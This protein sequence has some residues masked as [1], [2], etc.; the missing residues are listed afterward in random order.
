MN[1]IAIDFETYYDADCTVKGL[2]PDAYCRHP[3]FVPYMVSLHGD[4]IDYVGPTQD[5]PWCSIPADVHFVAHNAAFDSTVFEA[6]QRRGYIPGD[7]SPI[8]DCTANLGV[9]IQ[10]PR[11]LKG[12]SE[13]MLGVKP[14]KTVRD[15]MKGKLPSD[16]DEAELKTLLEYARLDAVYCHELWNTYER[17]WPYHERILARH[18]MTS[19]QRGIHIDKPKLD[20]GVEVLY[21][22]KEAAGKKVPWG[23][24]EEPINSLKQLKIYCA[25]EGIPAPASTNQNEPECAEWEADYGDKYP[26]VAALRDW[27]KSNR[28]LRIF[29]TINTRLR[30]DGT[31]PFGLKYFGATLTGR[32]SGDTGLNMQNLPRGESFG[33]DTR[34]LFVP[35]PG[36]KFIICDLAQIEPRVMAWLTGNSEMLDYIR[37]GED[38]YTAHALST[39]GLDKVDKQARQLA[40]IRVLGLGYGCGAIRFKQIADNWGVTLSSDEA[41]HTVKDFRRTNPEIL[42]YWRQREK[43]FKNDVNENHYHELPSGRHICYFNVRYKND[44]W[45]ASITRGATPRH[46]YGGKLAEN[47]VQATARDIFAEHYY[48]IV[49]AGFEVLWTVH[50]EII[51]EVDEDDSKSRAEIQNLMCRTPAWIKGCPVAAEAHE[52]EAYT[53]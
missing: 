5:A 4:G 44:Q 8:W 32:W 29:Q 13:Q 51:V 10:C 45:F 37:R 2:G 36:K 1:M 24:D 21:E 9:Y 43:E 49:R 18:T 28:L 15:K 6:A 33:I 34:S 16:L 12:F 26:V 40:K 27:R 3:K 41:E 30:D 35:R 38:L 42:K 11:N 52:A 47:V 23:A 31:M 48:N 50:D 20:A 14:D 39:M 25:K 46:W 19:G 22:I 7:L 17:Y 53:K